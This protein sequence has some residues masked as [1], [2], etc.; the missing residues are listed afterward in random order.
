MTRKSA[1]RVKPQPDFPLS[2]HASGQWANKI[3]GRMYYLGT[4]A[5]I[6]YLKEKDDLQADRV[7]RDQPS[8][9]LTLRNLFNRFLCAKRR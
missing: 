6:R 1:K 4:D 3:R 2:P 9:Q 5:L 8:R 7:P